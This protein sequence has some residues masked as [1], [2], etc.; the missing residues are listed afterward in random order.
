[1]PA[2]MLT[3]RCVA[4]E[5]RSV[6]PMRAVH[7]ADSSIIGSAGPCSFTTVRPC[8]RR[9][10]CPA[11]RARSANTIVVGFPIGLPERLEVAPAVIVAAADRRDVQARAREPSQKAIA[12]L[13]KNAPVMFQPPV[14]ISTAP[15]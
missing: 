14:A 7:S 5:A 15:S 9:R 8:R 6:S 4:V 11:P 13:V 1:M 12:S 10:G 2:V 3:D